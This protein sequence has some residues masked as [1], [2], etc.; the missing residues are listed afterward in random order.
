MLQSIESIWRLMVLVLIFMWSLLPWRLGWHGVPICLWV[1]FWFMYGRF[2]P[3]VL[4]W[5]KTRLEDA[6]P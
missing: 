6:A 2:L 3:K 1:T 4:G 5:L